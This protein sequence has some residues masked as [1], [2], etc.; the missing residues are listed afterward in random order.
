MR[1]ADLTAV[2]RIRDAA[3]AQFGEHGF[4][5]GLRSIAEAAGV[6]AALVI[7]HF[8]S[9]DGLRKACDDYVAEEIRISKSETI[10]S[11]DP[12]TWLAQLAEIESY[13][14]LMAYLVRSMV[15]GGELANLL[16]QRM[17]D[18]TEAYLEEGVRAGT[19]KPSRDPHARAKYL[20]IT[21]GGGFLL[22]LQMHPTPTDLRAVLR[23]YANDMV[24]PALEVYSEGLMTDRTMYDAFLAA[25]K[26][27]GGS[28]DN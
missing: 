24:L 23:D 9:K 28:H 3:I 20:G 7:H 27:K 11:N 15:S 1:S 8:G 5:V 6:S 2:A 22:Y 4:G 18:N 17:I 13:A 21:G 19:V 14:P 16:W 12:A 26:N 10:Q 25:E